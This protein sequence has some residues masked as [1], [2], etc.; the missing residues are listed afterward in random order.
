MHQYLSDWIGVYGQ[1]VFI[2]D[3]IMVKWEVLIC[4]RFRI[5]IIQQSV[6]CPL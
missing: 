1:Y 6:L 2:I 5:S 4:D 3:L